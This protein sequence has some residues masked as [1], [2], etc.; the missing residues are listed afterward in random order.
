MKV[1]VAG[2]SH[3]NT[4]SMVRSMGMEGINVDVILCTKGEKDSYV[5]SSKFIERSITTF[6]TQETVEIL[7]KEYSEALTIICSDDVSAL[8]NENNSYYMDK[9]RQVEI[10]QK[11]GMNVPMSKSI[12]VGKDELEFGTFP[13][14]VKPL[15]SILGGKRVDV[16]GEISTLYKALENYEEG[17]KVQIQQFIKRSCE[18]VVDGVSLPN[19]EIVIPGFIK[20]HRDIKGGTTYATSFPIKELPERMVD[21]IKQMVQTIGYEGLFG[22]EFV[23][24]DDE[25]FFIEMNLRND[26]TAYI[27]TIAGV[28]LPYIY[29]LSKLGLDYKEYTNREIRIINAMMEMRDFWFVLKGNVPF[30][31]WLKE[32]KRCECLYYYNKGDMAP[33]RMARNQ[34]ISSLLERVVKRLKYTIA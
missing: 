15:Q 23:L 8:M 32:L 10:A 7:K 16:C 6:T 1:V 13:C 25:Y 11:I 19:G 26:A 33:F 31:Q 29:Y 12:C 14:L 34:F 3:P 30:W 2:I 4:L 18:I 24:R 27:L 22:V 5:L 21:Q 9:Q 17:D 20:K 28:N